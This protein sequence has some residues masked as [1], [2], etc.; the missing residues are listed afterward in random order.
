MKKKSKVI[1]L[2]VK[3]ICVQVC[4]GCASDSIL[5]IGAI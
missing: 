2:E 1:G 5:E 4:E 3:V